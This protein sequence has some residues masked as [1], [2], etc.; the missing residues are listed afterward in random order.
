MSRRDGRGRLQRLGRQGRGVCVST[1]HFKGDF[2]KPPRIPP[3]LIAARS[4]PLLWVV[5]GLLLVSVILQ[6]I[7]CVTILRGVPAEI[8]N[9]G[10]LRGG[11]VPV[12]ITNYEVDVNLR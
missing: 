3:T 6:A 4:T 1:F 2:M 7:I 9:R 10:R 12:V 11:G 8:T 5:V